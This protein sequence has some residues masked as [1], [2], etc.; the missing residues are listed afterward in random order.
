MTFKIQVTWQVTWRVLILTFI[1]TFPSKALLHHIDDTTG[2][3]GK[4]VIVTMNVCDLEGVFPLTD[5]Y[6]T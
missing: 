2:L 1:F 3:R 6:V 4:D 5:M